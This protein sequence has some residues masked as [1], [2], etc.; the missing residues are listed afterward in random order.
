MA[1]RLGVVSFGTA[2]LVAVGLLGE[3]PPGPI[4]LTTSAAIEEVL[5]WYERRW[6][7]EDYH[8]AQKTGCQ[9]EAPQFTTE[10]RLQPVIAL[11]SVVAVLL[12]NGFSVVSTRNHAGSQR[13]SSDPFRASAPGSTCASQRI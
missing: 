11:L 2:A 3:L 10:E 13:N 9:I 5:G 4:A 7:V 8:K 1:A 6:T 12:V